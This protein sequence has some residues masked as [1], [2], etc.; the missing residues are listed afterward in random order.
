MK[1]K[2]LETLLAINRLPVLSPHEKRALSM[3]IHDIDTFSELTLATLEDIFERKIRSKFFSIQNC[4]HDA[5]QDSRAIA[6]HQVS[7]YTFDEYPR[8]LQLIHNAP[9]LLFVR[10]KALNECPQ[11]AVAIVG[12]RKPTPEAL[13]VA[14]EFGRKIACDRIPLVSGLAVGIDTAAMH[15]S[16]KSNGIVVAVIAN[17]IDYIYPAI[18]RTLAENIVRAGGS[19]VSEYAPGIEPKHYHF[20][21]RNRIISGLASATVII[22]APRNSGA[23]ITGEHAYKQGKKLFFHSLALRSGNSERRDKLVDYADTIS[24]Y[25]DVSAY[26]HHVSMEQEISDDCEKDSAHEDTG[27]REVKL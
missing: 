11:H 1:H 7:V 18:N 13:S 15:G 3:S 6:L 26:L 17:G 25:K 2:N 4:I 10:G 23:L 16:V 9:F 14:E 24:S 12:T 19:I 8:A 21:A 20:P 22:E 5:E 27:I